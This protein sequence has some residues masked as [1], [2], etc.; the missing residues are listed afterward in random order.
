MKMIGPYL[1]QLADAIGARSDDLKL[2]VTLA[3]LYLAMLV[4]VE[5]WQRDDGR[6]D[7]LRLF[8]DAIAALAAGAADP[9]D[10]VRAAAA[11]G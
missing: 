9:L 11:A 8:D 4:A 7:L 10:T 2:P 5:P 6:E 1:E 3:A